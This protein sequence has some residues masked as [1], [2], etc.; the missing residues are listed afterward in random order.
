MSEPT[1]TEHQAVKPR[2]FNSLTSALDAAVDAATGL[3]F[4]AGRGE[5]L[6]AIPYPDLARQ[7]RLVGRK[8]L[9]KGLKPGDRVGIVAET[10][11]DFVRS[12]M[13][14][15]YAHLVP[16]PL[17]LPV[18]F[19]APGVYAESLSRVIKVAE[20]NAILVSKEY[21]PLL[22][23]QL[24]DYNFL[25]LGAIDALGDEQEDLPTHSPN[26]HDL[27]YIQFSSGTTSAPKGIAI[28]HESVI[29]NIHAMTID[30]L[31]L[32]GSD[33]GAS[34]L[35][36][37]HDMGLVGG[38]LSPIA[39]HM[40]MDFLPTRD[41][42]RRPALW[43][44][45]ISRAGAT[46]SYAPSFGYQL[47]AKRK[48]KIDDL[49]LS[50]WRIA[51]IGGDMVMADSLHSFAENYKDYGFKKTS[52]VPS[53]GMAEVSLGATFSKLNQDIQTDR[54][55]LT[56]LEEGR[57]VLE[58]GSKSNTREFV[59]CGAVI[60]GHEI[61]IK[62][63]N[64]EIAKDREI[65]TVF[66]KGPSVMLGYHNNEVE[67]ARMLD[68]DGW[69]N[70]GDI[71]YLNE[72]NLTLTGREKDL[73]IIN[74]RNIWPQDIEWLVEGSVDRVKE[75]RS[76]AFSGPL[77][78][79]AGGEVICVVVECRSQDEATRQELKQAV[80]SVVKSTFSL[81]P[82]VALSDSGLI[83]KTSSGKLSRSKARSMYIE[84]AFQ[85]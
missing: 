73:I 26:P 35:P 12:F 68:E 78:K 45:M 18:A 28:S 75:G 72:G 69:L 42:I 19:S 36:F 39:I 20:P 46:L 70:T 51:G 50:S 82:I 21:L 38:V 29:A 54:L 11:G 63:S 48:P 80:E 33:R 34:W 60:K 64:G 9:A 25:F 61:M 71:G 23:N 5:L 15:L 77:D 2:D 22:N 31:E 8:L 6:E 74:G 62:T 59:S 52:F 84:G 43:L 79:E 57:V 66:L 40:S 47:A 58:N 44:T 37:Y 53:Y 76:I 13:G 83:P 55:E 1:K 4:F 17:P 3:N 49:D 16:C 27:A 81:T 41:F 67:T 30:A 7:A 32:S 14:S 24:T 56:A 65:G 85:L 10:E